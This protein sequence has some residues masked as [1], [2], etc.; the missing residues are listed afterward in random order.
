VLTFNAIEI[1]TYLMI[2]SK[3][4]KLLDKININ[5]AASFL[6]SWKSMKKNV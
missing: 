4:T 6:T 5:G 1:E 2:L 3:I